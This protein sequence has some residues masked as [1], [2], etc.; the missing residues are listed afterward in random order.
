MIH[1]KYEGKLREAVRIMPYSELTQLA[2]EIR[3]RIIES[4]AKNGGHLASNLGAVELTLALHRTFNTPEDKIIW[5]VGHQTY[6]HKMITGR[7]DDFDRLRQLGGISGFPKRAESVHDMYDSGHSGTSV[8]AALGYANARDLNGEDY[9][10]VAVIGDGAITGGVAFEALS[11]AGSSKTSLIVVLNDNTMSI[12]KNVGGVSKYLVNLRTSKKYLSLK[13]N[14]KKSI[15]NMPGIYSGLEKVRD[16]VRKTVMPDTIFDDLGFKY[17]GPIDGHNI[18]EMCAAFEAAKLQNRPVL[19]HV[20]TK[21]GKGFAPAEQNPTKYHGIGSF[22]PK[23]ADAKDPGVTDSWSDIFGGILLD[24]AKKDK[25]IVAITAAMLSATGLDQMYKTYPNRV[26]DTAIAEQS[27]VSFAAG[28]T[29]GGI[30]PVVAIYSTFLQRAYDQIIT[31]VCLQ[32]LPV[33]FAIDRAGVTGHDGETHQGVFD[34]AYLRSMPGMTILSPSNAAELR[35]CMEY[36][37]TLEAPCAI[38]YPRGKAPEGGTCNDLDPEMLRTGKDAVLFT[39]G[40]MVKTALKAAEML[41][42]KGIELSIVNLKILK[43]LPEDKIREIVSPYAA[44][45]T[46]EDGCI[47]GGVGEEIG[48]IC[49][50]LNRPPRV[51]NLGWPDKFIEHGSAAELAELYGLDAAGISARMEEFLENKA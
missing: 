22:D 45:A 41:A 23:T 44:A 49:G 38:R 7:W 15:E 21:K 12:G 14:V 51:L 43:P 29:L 28:L 4:V 17:Y 18:Q 33:I 16:S 48:R 5:D 31:E 50:S 47:M 35:K 42:Q 1:E 46:L 39:S 32:D 10:C 11:S 3:Q 30:R 20:I 13:E 19:V 27:A 34:I 36:A 6:V 37:H 24:L 25:R 9:S 40:S 2:S 26:F 8:A